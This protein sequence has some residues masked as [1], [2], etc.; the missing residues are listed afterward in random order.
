VCLC[1]EDPK[2]NIS[3]APRTPKSP[4]AP[5]QNPSICRVFVKGGEHGAVFCAESSARA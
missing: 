5:S 1:G 3:P 4:L 2:R